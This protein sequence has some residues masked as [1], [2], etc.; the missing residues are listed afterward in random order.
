MNHFGAGDIPMSQDRYQ[1]LPAGQEMVHVPFALGAIGIFHSVP[2]DQ[3]VQL[4]ACLL[5]KIFSGLVTTWDD[6]EVMAQN[7]GLSVPA[8]QK[9]MVGH[10]TKGSSSTGGTTGYIEKKT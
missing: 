6:A 7:P 1:S 3:T 5:G 9:I 8:G 2:G 4:D 10:R